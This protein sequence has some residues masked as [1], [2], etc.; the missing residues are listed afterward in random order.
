[1]LD[2]LEAGG[3]RVLR[4]T[5]P[6]VAPFRI[7]FETP[8]EER[9]GIVVYAFFANSKLTKNRPDDEHRFQ[10]KYGPDDK[11]LHRIWQ[12]PFL[13]YTTLFCGI[14]PERGIF[15]GADP[16]LHNPTR[17][18]I[19]VEYK[20]EDVVE[21]LRSGWHSWERD[22]RSDDDKPVEVLVGGTAKSFLRYVRFEREAV[23]EDQGHRMLL[24]E[25]MDRPAPPLVVEPVGLVVS[26]PGPARLHA[27][28][29]EFEMTEGEVLDLIASARRLK[30]AVRGWVAEEHLVRR[31]TSVPGVTECLR[32]DE[33]GGPDV[34][35]TFEGSRLT[36]E[37]KNVLRQTTAEG[38]VR[39]DFQRTRA[40]KGDPCSRYYGSAEF[41]VLAACLH[42]VTERWEFKYVLPRSL[43]PHRKC[44]SKLSNNVKVDGRW[45]D[46][47]VKVLRSAAS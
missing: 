28:A 33:E 24:A 13:L 10:V 31:L 23:A 5:E 7:T 34:N 30:M 39:V 29:Q 1:M 43:D 11:K 41:D 40:S 44:P 12:D 32:I 35:L 3:C 14:D 17:F 8:E 25:R 9:L 27:L 36:V 22:H 26:T 37:C 20:E 19:S 4:H 46:Q 38:L 42:A 45:T 16:V 21:I 47:V 6:D 2:A 18:F 15:V